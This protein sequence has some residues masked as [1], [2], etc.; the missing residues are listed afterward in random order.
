M[1]FSLKL[2]TTKSLTFHFLRLLLFAILVVTCQSKSFADTLIV[3]D[4]GNDD[5]RFF[6]TDT[7]NFLGN[8]SSSTLNIRNPRGM[9]IHPTTGHLLV[10]DNGSGNVGIHEFDIQNDSYLGIFGNTDTITS[11]GALLFHPVSGNLLANKVPVDVQEIDGTTG[12][13]IGTFGDTGAN[14]TIQTQGGF[15]VHPTSGNLFMVDT[16]GVQE[17]DADGNFVQTFGTTGTNLNFPADLIFH[18]VTGNLLVADF[19]ND[20]VREFDG[21]DG[22]FVGVFGDTGDLTGPDTLAFHPQDNSLLIGDSDG[23]IKSFNGTTGALIGPFGQTTGNAGR[24]TDFVVTSVSPGGVTSGGVLALDTT[25]P[26]IIVVNADTQER[27]GF[28]TYTISNTGDSEINYRVEGDE[29]WLK[30][31]SDQNNTLISESLSGT[32]QANASLATFVQVELNSALLLPQGFHQGTLRFLNDTN[33]QGTTTRDAILLLGGG[34][35]ASLPGL[36]N[37]P[38]PASHFFCTQGGAC[39]PL[40]LEVPVGNVSESTLNLGVEVE[41]S[42]DFI[43]VQYNTFSEFLSN[44]SSDTSLL[45]PQANAN[46]SILAGDGGVI[47]LTPNNNVTTLPTGPQSIMFTLTDTDSNQTLLSQ[48]TR[49]FIVKDPF[50]LAGSEEKAISPYWQADAQ[51]YTFLAVSHSSLSAM[52]SEIGVSVA[53][54]VNEGGPFGLFAEFTIS[55]G[56]SKKV[57]IVSTNNPVINASN[58]PNDEFI[59]G[60]AEGGHGQLIFNPIA[61]ATAELAESATDR[62]YRDVTMLNLWGAV[63]VQSTSTGFA[64]EF[65]GDTQ[66]SR[67]IN[68]SGF[69]GLN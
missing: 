23:S 55:R 18:P 5:I 7:G 22:S 43:N 40:K 54:I 14:L 15:A 25:D 34:T 53:A 49:V 30:A 59:V 17:F 27:R 51:T 37:A 12:N 29:A 33:G 1:L 35:S 58:L 62:G 13:V 36:I 31:F 61:T 20:D 38:F 26:H 44:A 24:A 9:A 4:S 42:G 52:N 46:F 19:G 56:Q 39:N 50:N 41:S 21:T 66:D 64:M 68:A 32:L 65:V 16:F 11:P 69:S 6:D 48:T 60:N 45:K 28:S 57:F 8:L 3:A 67:A 2:Q 10:A 47:A 63:V